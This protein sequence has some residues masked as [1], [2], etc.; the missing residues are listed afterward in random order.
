MENKR[1]TTENLDFDGIKNGFKTFLMG[2]DKFSDYNFEGSGLSILLDILAYNTHYNALY[3]NLAVNEAFLDSASKRNSVVSKAKELGYVP[4][5]YRCSKTLVNVLLNFNS[6]FTDSYIELP[7]YTR[8]YAK[9]E[10]QVYHF[11]TTKSAIAYKNGRT[12]HFKDLEIKQGYPLTYRY[13]A[14]TGTRYKIPN[15]KVDI[16]T[17]RV[18]VQENLSSSTFEVYKPASSLLELNS[19]SLVYFVKEVENEYFEIEFGN[20]V[21]GKGLNNGNV[22]VFD[23]MTCDGDEANDLVAFSYGGKTFSTQ[24]TA[25][26]SVQTPS[27]GGAGLEDVESIRYNAPHYYSAQNRCVTKEDYKTLITSLFPEAK[28]IAV[29]GGEENDPPI[30]G[31]VYLSIMPQQ[32]GVLSDIEKRYLLN[33]V[34]AARQMMSIHPVF[35]D[36]IYLNL[37]LNITYYYDSRQTNLY[38]NDINKLIINNVIDYS[39]ASISKFD[40]VFRQSKVTRLIDESDVSILNSVINTKI[41]YKFPIY[42]NKVS[43]YVININNEI[44]NTKTDNESIIS[45]GIVVSDKADVTSFVDDVPDTTNNNTGKLRLFYYLHGVKQLLRYIGDINYS[46]GVIRIS[47]LYIISSTSLTFDLTVTPKNPDITSYRNMI[48]VIEKSQ[49]S[50]TAVNVAT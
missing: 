12:F 35:V 39:D 43:P 21:I 16:D 14:Q 31:N 10:P 40:G 3:T 33:D 28:S 36:P 27:F 44:L 50:L 19:D 30:Y 20:N 26:V 29:W 24:Q 46:T 15:L 5:S 6:N 2:Q 9:G 18:T 4:R 8:F 32:G 37:R 47:N 45:N 23:Y 13:I 48:T 1:I 49:L 34:L 17:L 41:L 22:L 25:I 42:F 11:Y 38:S 7:K